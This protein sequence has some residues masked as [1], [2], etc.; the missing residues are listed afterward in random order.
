MSTLSAAIGD[1]PDAARGT[2]VTAQGTIKSKSGEV[3]T[4][5]VVVFEE[6]VRRLPTFSQFIVDI[7]GAARATTVIVRGTVVT[8]AEASKLSTMSALVADIPG[9]A[10]VALASVSS[11]AGGAAKG[12]PSAPLDKEEEARKQ[13]QKHAPHAAASERLRIISEMEHAEH[14]AKKERE[15]TRK[16]ASEAMTALQEALVAEH[17]EGARKAPSVPG[18][19]E[20]KARHSQAGISGE[21]KELGSWIENNVTSDDK[22]KSNQLEQ[23][24]KGEPDMPD[25]FHGTL[26]ANAI[27]ISSNGFDK[28]RRAKNPTVSIGY[29]RGGQCML[30]C[31]LSL[32]VRFSILEN[33]DG[34]HIWVPS[35]GYYV[36][37][38]LD[39]VLFQYIIK[40]RTGQFDHG[41]P[42]VCD[43]L[44]A[45]LANGFFTKAA[46]QIVPVLRQQRP[47]KMSRETA[48]VLWMSFFHSHV[49]DES[50][51]QDVNRSLH[52]LAASDMD[53][54]KKSK[55]ESAE[56]KA[57][58]EGDLDV[59]SKDLAGDVKELQGLH[60]NCVTKIEGLKQ[61]PKAAARSFRLWTLR[62]R[63]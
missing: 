54:A 55:S 26:S 31:R 30:V 46:E 18:S 13:S 12:E 34:D 6:E 22:R 11:G 24:L 41:G 40:F 36:V 35:N 29:S 27:S 58:A 10:R 61:S 15:S 63:L 45:S 20:S 47:C 28:G 16:S 3:V 51:R 2:D 60:R 38:E 56:G 49:S 7:S 1:T 48:T 8:S 4:A 50:L 57:T 9:A 5:Q 59:A 19:A 53:E 17:G 32:C 62:R 37:K 44:E 25:G 43:Q 42:V 39:Q 33:K 23:I 52:K 21:E 14:D